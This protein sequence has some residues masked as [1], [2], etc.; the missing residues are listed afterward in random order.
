MIFT[1]TFDIDQIEQVLVLVPPLYRLP[2]HQV[3]LLVLHSPPALENIPILFSMDI[4][5]LLSETLLPHQI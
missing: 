5:Q 3:L 2:D 1:W 4:C